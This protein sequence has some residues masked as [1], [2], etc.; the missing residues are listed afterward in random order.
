MGIEDQV[1]IILQ[2]GFAGI[3]LAFGFLVGKQFALLIGVLD[4]HLASLTMLIEDC[5]KKHVNK[6]PPD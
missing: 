2:F 4:K 5:V 1:G 3:L 6:L